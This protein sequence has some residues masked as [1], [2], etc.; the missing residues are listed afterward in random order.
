M[1]VPSRAC[2]WSSGFKVLLPLHFPCGKG[3]C[4]EWE[5][6]EARSWAYKLCQAV[7]E[8]KNN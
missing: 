6:R 8:F 5:E 4:V 7:K 1:N 3:L 2:G